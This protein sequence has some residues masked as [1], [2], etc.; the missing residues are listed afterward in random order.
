MKLTPAKNSLF[1]ILM[2][3]PWWVSF[4]VAGVLGLVA[5]ALVPAGYRV[6]GALSGLPFAVVGC[7]ALWRQRDLPSAARV[8]QARQALAQMAWAEFEQKLEATL[9]REGWEVQRGSAPPVDFELRRQGRRT[10]VSARRW[11]TARVGLEALRQLQAARDAADASEAV[12][13]SLGEL[14]DSARP[15]ALRER[16]TVWGAGE[17]ARLLGRELGAGSTVPQR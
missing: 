13:V 10:L 3:S 14:S 1:A 4:A 2:R 5:A 9:R 17:L 7:I 11:K 8:E 12:L 15:F 16:I 6:V